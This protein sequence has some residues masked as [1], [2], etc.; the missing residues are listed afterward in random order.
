MLHA[1]N[2]TTNLAESWMNI[3][4]KFDGGKQYNRSQRGSWDG[5]C[6]GAGLQ[7]IIGPDW[8]PI[9]WEKSI[10]KEANPV[11]SAAGKT[12]VHEVENDRKRK[13]S[14]VVKQKRLATKY[15]KNQ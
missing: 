9:I 7:Q 14:E 12:R 4:A 2:F 11:F 15:K 5:R 1:G 10:G 6:A 8:G 13:S 3:R